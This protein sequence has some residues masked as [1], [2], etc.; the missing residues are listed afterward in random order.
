[1]A[2]LTSEGLVID[3]QPDVVENLI[4][5]YK[6][7]E[8]LENISVR[9]DEKFGQQTNIL[10]QKIAE[11]Y[12]LLQAVNDSQN[13]NKAEGT[14][15]DDV[16]AFNLV[17]R[18]GATKSF[19]STQHFTQK[20]GFNIPNGSI[21]ENPSTL[22]R[23]VTTANIGVNSSSCVKI[24]YKVDQVLDTT[25]YRVD[26]NSVAYT[27]TSDADA[28][29]LEIIT[30]LK[31]SL[32]AVASTEFIT[33]L[34]LVNNYLVIEATNNKPLA[35]S[36][37]AYLLSNDITV[38]GYVES[39]VVGSI[40]APS[41]SVTRMVTSSSVVT[42]NP[43]AYT[44]GRSKESDED[45]R[46]RIISSQSASGKATVE[47]I[48]DDTSLVDG[49]TTAKV[50]ENDTSVTDAA[51]RP[52]HSFETIVQ[53]GTDTDIGAAVL[54]A[55]PAGIQAF[56]NTPLVVTDKYGNDRDISITRPVSIN[57]AF[58]V[59]YTEHTESTFP[60]EG[61]ALIESTLINKVNL[62]QLGQDVIPITYFGD[63]ISAVGSLELLEIRVQVIANQ[64]DAPNPANWQT[65]KLSISETEFASTTNADVVVLQV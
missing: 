19:T 42:T 36:T 58:E 15:L 49:V 3:R 2:G 4:T 32:D 5:S 18:Q 48:Q 17:A 45:Y 21:L 13:P 41:N 61:A 20:A 40:N 62:S 11:I 37:P 1:M 23:F 9:D 60:P 8:G 28:T 31:A 7:V 6:E 34:D 12:E 27:Y 46:I 39:Q 57:L 10:A 14:N 51:G 64:G 55:K 53:G 63:I 29:S 25:L 43:I 54:T 26:V 35:I 44:Q 47:A 59:D 65:T 30:G 56:G 22:D 24:E 16:G 33:S 52:E 50:V 38:I